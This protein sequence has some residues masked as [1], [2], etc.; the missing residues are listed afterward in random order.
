MKL[1]YLIT[2]L[3]IACG[4]GEI[5]IKGIQVNVFI[6]SKYYKLLVYIKYKG[7]CMHLQI[8]VNVLG[9]SSAHTLLISSIRLL[10]PIFPRGQNVK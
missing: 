5:L 6:I 10:I 2:R 1:S 3:Y 8:L 4:R 9:W 7:R